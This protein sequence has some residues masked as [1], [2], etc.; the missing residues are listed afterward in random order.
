MSTVIGVHLDHD[1]ACGYHG[2]GVTRTPLLH[3]SAEQQAELVLVMALVGDFGR[4]FPPTRD[5]TRVR[6]IAG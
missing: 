5:H 6:K 1:P 4:M 2:G 3:V